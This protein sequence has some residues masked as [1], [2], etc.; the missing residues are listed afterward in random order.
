M[1]RKL[2][3]LLAAFLAFRGGREVAKSGRAATGSAAA[4]ES[5]LGFGSLLTLWLAPRWLKPIMIARAMRR[6][7]R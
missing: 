6:P 4:R 7:P 3:L 1:M 5:G 2:F